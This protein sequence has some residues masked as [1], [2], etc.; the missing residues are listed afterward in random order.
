MA[1]AAGGLSASTNDGGSGGTF[2]FIKKGSV[3]FAELSSSLTINGTAYTLESNIA[4]LANA[5]AGNPNGSYA[6]ANSY[7]ASADGTYSSAPIGVTFT[8]NA[9]GLGNTITHLSVDDLTAGDDVGLFAE[10]GSGGTVSSIRLRSVQIG[11]VDGSDIGSLI[12]LSEGF[13][14]GCTT[15]GSSVKMLKSTNDLVGYVGGLVGEMT[16]GT[17]TASSTNVRVEG[18]DKASAVGGLV[19]IMLGGTV[20]DSSARGEV[21]GP[22]GA[23]GLVGAIVSGE[24]AAS[25]ATGAVKGRARTSVGGLAG[26]NSGTIANSYATGSATGGV[27]SAVGGLVGSNIQ[28]SIAESYSTGAPVGKAKAV[29]GGFVGVNGGVME[30]GYWDTTT[31]GTTTGVGDG[32]AKGVKGLT[33]EELQAGLPNGFRKK[34]W[35]ENPNINNGLPYLLA[36]PPK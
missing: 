2:A 32:S 28:G 18:G 17:L 12:G 29:I 33:T 23:G 25:F 9:T 20:S 34:I 14:I 4:D 26:G 15:T 3:T 19:G 24:L 22:S 13:V 7:D 36:N 27:R 35:G 1:V 16:D 21:R 11:G 31:S 6:L 5:I 30:H 8:G 10:V